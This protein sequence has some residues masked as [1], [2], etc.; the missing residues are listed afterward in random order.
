MKPISW[1]CC[2]DADQISIVRTYWWRTSRGAADPQAHGQPD[3]PSDDHTDGSPGLRSRAHK[4][5]V[6]QDASAKLGAEHGAASVDGERAVRA[7][8]SAEPRSIATRPM[9]GAAQQQRQ[10]QQHKAPKRL[11]EHR[12]AFLAALKAELRAARQHLQQ[13]HVKDPALHNRSALRT[14]WQRSVSAFATDID[15]EKPLVPAQTQRPAASARTLPRKRPRSAR[16]VDAQHHGRDPA[17]ALQASDG[18]YAQRSPLLL[19]GES[20]S[21][22]PSPMH[23]ITV[24]VVTS[25][26]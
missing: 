1:T 24:N 25:A 6:G 4:T 3:Q 11:P 2:R 10:G 22:V 19:P 9:A 20:L 7:A 13:E 18:S 14:S 16:P 17:K 21:V 8:A 23:H 15:T 26:P 12:F 5:T